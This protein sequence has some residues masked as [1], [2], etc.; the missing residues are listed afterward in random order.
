MRV[1]IRSI[2]YM[3]S[4][5]NIKEVARSVLSYPIK[6]LAALLWTSTRRAGI[7]Y[8]RYI[9]YNVAKLMA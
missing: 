7:F 9:Y 6:S 1:S 8:S 5:V 2:D 3:A 4:C